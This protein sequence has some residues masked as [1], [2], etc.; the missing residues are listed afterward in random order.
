MA[1]QMVGEESIFIVQ[2]LSDYSD[3][4]GGNKSVLILNP[5]H[6]NRVLTNSSIFE[7]TEKL[8]NVDLKEK[9]PLRQTAGFNFGSFVDIDQSNADLSNESLKKSIPCFEKKSE[10]VPNNNINPRMMMSSMINERNKNFNSGEV[11]KEHISL[12]SN[13]GGIKNEDLSMPPDF[14]KT[15]N[16][17]SLVNDKSLFELSATNKSI[18]NKLAKEGN[19][20]SL[21]YDEFEDGD[22]GGFDD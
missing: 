15:F 8:K 18:Q 6:A 20:M 21:K 17:N 11:G 14:G 19:D 13:S 22:Y 9:D 4:L 2:Q 12:L 10:V 3:S 5:E 16:L 1:N 7:T